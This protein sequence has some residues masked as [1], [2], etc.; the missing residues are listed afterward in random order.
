[1]D[2]AR[3]RLSIRVGPAWFWIADFP[4][5]PPPA[6][7]WS[8]FS[9]DAYAPDIFLTGAVYVAASCSVAKGATIRAT[10]NRSRSRHAPVPRSG[11]VLWDLLAAPSEQK[12]SARSGNC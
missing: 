10:K 5:Y 8:Y 4:V 3:A 6:L 11:F 9:F 7:F 1:M 2:C 12:V